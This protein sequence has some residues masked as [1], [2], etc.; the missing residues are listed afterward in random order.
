MGL[1]IRIGW[2]R[3]SA[4]SLIVLV[5]ACTLK[6]QAALQITSPADGTMVN[7][8]Q[9]LNVTVSSSGATFAQVIVMGQ[10]PMGFSQVLTAPPYQFSIQIPSDI[11]PGR[12]TLTASGAISP[13]QGAESDPIS[14]DVERPDAPEGMSTDPSSLT[15]PVGGQSGLRVIGYYADGSSVDLSRSTQ[16]TYLSQA[17]GA[18]TVTSEG[19]VTA[20]TPGTTNIV[21]NGNMIVPVTVNSPII[22]NPAQAT[23]SGSRTRQFVARVTNPSNQAITWSISPDEAGTIDADGLYTAPA[24][25]AS[26]QTVTLTATSVADST[27]TATASIILSPAASVSIVPAWATLYRAQIQQFTERQRTPEPLE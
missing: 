2:V 26:Q 6:A 24:F 10:D 17:P 9:T 21:I 1:L 16:I 8:G 15:L 11:R 3:V 19:L 22:L 20:V 4:A 12:Y 25:I 7:P 23:L 13:E 18:A 14:I 27:Q 5:F